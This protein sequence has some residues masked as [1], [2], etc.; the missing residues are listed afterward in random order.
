MKN[1]YD[2]YGLSRDT[3]K[4]EDE[5]LRKLFLY[6]S[7]KIVIEG[8][9]SLQ[10]IINELISTSGETAGHLLYVSQRLDECEYILYKLKRIPILG[11]IIRRMESQL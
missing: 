2:N 9:T 5:A 1:I 3:L 10:T 7:K 8:D 11:F 6:N 4:K